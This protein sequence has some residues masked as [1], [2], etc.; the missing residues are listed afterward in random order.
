MLRRPLH[1]RGP[2]LPFHT[3]TCGHFDSIEPVRKSILTACVTF[4]CNL[5][6]SK[7]LCGLDPE[8]FGLSS[9]PLRLSC[10]LLVTTCCDAPNLGCAE[11]GIRCAAFWNRSCGIQRIQLPFGVHKHPQ[12]MSL[13]C[14]FPV[15]LARNTGTGFAQWFC[16]HPP[17]KHRSCGLPM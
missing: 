6:T 7:P 2:R 15:L 16:V 8:H 10:R 11:V 13:V 17:T 5:A 9:S 14:L 3:Q 12:T 4:P 1:A